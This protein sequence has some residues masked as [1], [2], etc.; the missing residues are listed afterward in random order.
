M[1]HYLENSFKLSI[2]KK[3]VLKILSPIWAYFFKK[4]KNMYIKIDEVKGG[5]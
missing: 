4:I 2:N 1:R 3:G 5:R